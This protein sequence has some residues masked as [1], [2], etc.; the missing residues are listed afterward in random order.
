VLDS[1]SDTVAGVL[2]GFTESA[3]N[4]SQL[5]GVMQDGMAYQVYA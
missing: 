2:T 1:G 3:E 4:Y 5:I